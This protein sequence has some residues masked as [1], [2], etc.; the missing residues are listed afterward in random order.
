MS[1]RLV[2]GALSATYVVPR[3]HPDETAVRLRLDRV[4]RRLDRVLA[5]PV[6]RLA[7][8]RDDEVWLFR[9]LDAAVELDL[10]ADDD[11]LER[12]W[13]DGVV[14]AL[15][16]HLRVRP[17]A[18]E[19]GTPELVDG[20]A[21]FA[22]RAEQ[23]ASF[24]A[25]LAAGIAWSRWWHAEFDGLRPLPTATA[26][27]HALVRRR[28]RGRCALARLATSDRLVPVLQALDARAAVR[29]AEELYG[30][31]P[32]RRAAPPAAA[33][34]ALRLGLADAAAVLYVLAQ[35]SRSSSGGTSVRAARR[36]VAVAGHEAAA[37]PV[38][39][40]NRPAPSRSYTRLGGAFLLLR[41]LAELGAP[42]DAETRL[43]VLRSA[44]GHERAF[45]SADD[46]V[47]AAAAGVG[48]DEESVD[49]RARLETETARF[50]VEAG[51]LG[52]GGDDEELAY[53]DLP[54]APA[55]VAPAG[56]ALVRAL[57]QR[58]GGFERSSPRHLWRNVLDRPA[59][60]DTHEHGLRVEL[61]PAP[62]DVL[63]RLS[64]LAADRFEVPWLGEVDL[65]IER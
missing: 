36:A 46:P 29:V 64:G 16:A 54:A 3:T 34:R 27:E 18:A 57:A 55:A 50:L 2:V 9:S 22:D 17:R 42:L 20:I 30:D 53:Y 49:P 62:L 19:H 56:R 23:V 12:A 38:M 8:G 6:G 45:E 60:V 33:A 51:L 52:A 44:L 24:A 14:A 13:A 47:L 28:A 32:G 10:A 21:S 25:D 58:L 65:S 11:Q 1:G 26:I 59:R 37:T 61:G 39:R 43:L 7:A 35:A 63:L 41:S 48:V 4:A 40:A 15:A 31:V 5:T